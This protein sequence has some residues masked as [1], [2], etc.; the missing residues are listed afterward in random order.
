MIDGDG[1]ARIGDFGH[2]TFVGT[3]PP[4]QLGIQGRGDYI[5]PERLPDPD[6]DAPEPGA[7]PASDVFAF[8][9]LLYFVV[10]GGTR[11]PFR[12]PNRRSQ[13]FAAVM[14]VWRG[15]R[16]SRPS[17][18]DCRGMSCGDELWALLEACLSPTMNERPRAAEVVL[19]LQLIFACELP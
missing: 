2:A 7:H 19:R 11:F 6:T 10:T 18:E 8:G 9:V 14:N 15:A 13:A 17:S 3:P 12:D 16:P 4:Q 5:A 1:H